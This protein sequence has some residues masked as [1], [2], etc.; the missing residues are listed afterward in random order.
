MRSKLKTN[1]LTQLD[2]SGTQNS[3]A[4]KRQFL[5]TLNLNDDPDFC[6]IFKV[7]FNLAKVQL[8]ANIFLDSKSAPAILLLKTRVGL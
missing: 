1:Y 3:A 2:S 5:G 4:V 6:E 7:Y 8:N